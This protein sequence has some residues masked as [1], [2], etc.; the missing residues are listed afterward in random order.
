VLLTHI[1]VEKDIGCAIAGLEA[2]PAI[3][4][5]V[6]RIRMEEFGK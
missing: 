1:T 5:K 6:I 4:G 2:L 3:S